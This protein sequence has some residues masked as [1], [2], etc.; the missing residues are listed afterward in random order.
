[1]GSYQP[2][3]LLKRISTAINEGVKEIWLTSED[4][5]AYGRDIGTNIA[6]LLNLLVD[7]MP[8]DVMLRVGM[9]NP[10]YILEHLEAVG[11]ILRHPRVFAFLH[12]PVQSGNDEVL[13]KMNREYTAAEFCKVADYLLQHVPEMTIA[14][15]IICGFPGG[16]ALSFCS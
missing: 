14:T 1:L 6:H 15:D 7:N 5:G 11:K 16:F 4:T 2:A 13:D 8:E 9:T 10:P 3:A 12:I